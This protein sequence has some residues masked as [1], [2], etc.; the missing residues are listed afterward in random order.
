MKEIKIGSPISLNEGEQFVCKFLAKK[1]FENNRKRGI[2]NS[3]IGDQNDEITDLNGLGAEFSFCK[4]FNIYPDLSIFIR[5]SKQGE[6]LGDT[7]LNDGRTVDVKTTT[8][9]NGK[10]LAVPWKQNKVDLFVLMV[11]DFPNYV[12]K[13]FMKSE[14]LINTNRLGNLGHGPT[15]IA[16]Q[17][18]L[19]EIEKIEESIVYEDS[20]ILDLL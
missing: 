5:S 10:L 1:R 11:G 18:E 13:G 16:Y 2:K 8:Y 12:F 9:T 17:Q 19:K 6:D 14:I 15:Y 7:V 3:R 4:L 20:S